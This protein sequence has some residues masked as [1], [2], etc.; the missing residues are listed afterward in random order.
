M[1]WLWVFITLMEWVG[2]VLIVYALGQQ[3]ELFDLKKTILYFLLSGVYY[4]IFWYFHLPD[5]FTLGTYVLLFCYIY[6]MY[7]ESF[8]RSVLMLVIS[9]M[10][11]GTLEL[12]LTQILYWISPVEWKK[13][14]LEA[15]ASIVLVL[16]CFLF[17]RMKSYKILCIF[18]KWEL[19]YALVAVL[20]LMIFTPVFALKIVK[21]LDVTEYIYITAC[22]AAMWMLVSKIQKY[23]LENRIRKKYFESFTDVINQIR[24]RQHKVK[25]Q[26]NTAFGLYHMYD[27][28]DEL[29]EKQ[30]EYLGRLW[31]YE[32]PTDAIIL[33][34]PVVVAL[35]Y[36]KINEAIEHGIEVETVFSCSILNRKVSDVIWVEI[37]GTLLDN[38]MEALET[39]EGP[40]KLW[41][42]I[43][44]DQYDPERISICVKNT[45]R[46]LEQ[47]ELEN[48][49]A[50]GYSTKGEDRGI[51]LY[52]V[53]Q[54]VYKEK[55]DLV[56]QNVV[57]SG[58]TC[59]QISIVI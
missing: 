18:D 46:P 48:M 36:E 13:G 31:D 9:L 39:Y 19:S 44:E 29:V 57:Y 42:T 27:N 10:I 3:R 43:E 7:H 1:S 4:F 15:V 38:A 55:G 24:R 51:G 12:L 41:I 21:K 47:Q 32:L 50:I 37:L 20:S 28:Y 26:F 52:D 25:N 11:L 59:F 34:D 56:P 35:L 23:N 33:E 16:C 49:F 53:K 54:L 22:I 58:M 40:R 30:K 45:F 5:S 14:V 2:I 17:T 8:S 6:W